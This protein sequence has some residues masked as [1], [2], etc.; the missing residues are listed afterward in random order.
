[1]NLGSATISL[2]GFGVQST[3]HRPPGRRVP[4]IPQLLSEGPCLSTLNLGSDPLVHK[5]AH[6]A[7][8]GKAWRESGHW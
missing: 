2:W 4:C 7:D 3:C 1:V 8:F 6:W 5:R